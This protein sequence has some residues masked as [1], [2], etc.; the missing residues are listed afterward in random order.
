MQQIMF[1]NLFQK[2][3]FI[4]LLNYLDLF[5]TGTHSIFIKMMNINTY[6]VYSWML[7]KMIMDGFVT[8]ELRYIAQNMI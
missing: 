8:L 6:M 3:S 4:S 1:Q 7:I 5:I 2:I